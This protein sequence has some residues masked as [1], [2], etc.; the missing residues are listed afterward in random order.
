MNAP[1]N[2]NERPYW[3]MEVEPL[4]NTPAMRELQERRLNVLIRRLREGAPYYTRLF[5]EHGVH[6]DRIKT[7][8]EF[9]RALPV[10]TN[11]TY[12][13]LTQQYDGNIL[14]VIQQ[15]TPVSAYADLYL[16]ATTTGT[17]GEPKPYPMTE[18]DAWEFYG[19][20]IARYGWRAGVRR[21]D[22]VLLCYGLSMVIAGIPSMVGM[23]KI[24]ALVLPVGAEAGTERI[25]KT[26]HYFKPT[27]I[28]G[29]PSLMLY[30]IEKAPEVLGR[31]VG[32]LGIRVAIC[33]GEPGAG[34]PE[35]RQRIESAFGCKLYDMGAA[36]GISCGHETY[37]GMHSVGDDFM[38]FE[39]VDPDSKAPLPF[40]HGQRGE[41][42]YT[43]IGG[44]AWTWV[45][46]SPGDIMEVYTEPCLCGSSGFRYRVVGRVDDMLKVK[47]VMVYPAMIR[48]II[49]TFV[50]RVTGQFRI[51]LDEP[52]P[53]VVPPLKLR[54]EYGEHV[55]P[56]Q[57]EA[58]AH[59]IASTMSTKIK[60]N[61]QILWQPPGSLER[62][63]YK[64]KTFERLYEG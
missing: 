60:V 3:N 64:G 17:T 44:E 8:E 56:D 45:R 1:M 52:P 54:L 42:V 20:V 6:E 49:E 29:T 50:P 58:L 26:A 12:R 7:F 16:L 11:D 23:W 13:Q 51:V 35:V 39:L 9:R 61:P 48:S 21:G 24:G 34:V 18:F 62:S 53:R 55:P 5:A 28:M 59:E 46:H 31:D 32:T 2:E 38:I 14:E 43:I 15:L 30:L 36:L 37:Q 4:F 27:V 19:E 10:F 25:L 40:E 22:R 63:T 33:G 41:A 57:L 47:G